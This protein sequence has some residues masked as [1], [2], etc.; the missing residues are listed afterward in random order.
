MEAWVLL[1]ALV[2]I[3]LLLVLRWAGMRQRRQL[4]DARRRRRAEEARRWEEKTGQ[5]VRDD[6]RP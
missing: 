2:T 3:G 4:R 5:F 6:W 1:F